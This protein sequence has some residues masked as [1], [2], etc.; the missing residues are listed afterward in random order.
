MTNTDQ[1]VHRYGKV[2]FELNGNSILMVLISRTL[3]SF[4]TREYINYADSE[5][6]VCEPYV[7]FII[8]GIDR[9]G[10]RTRPLLPEETASIK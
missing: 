6:S 2:S 5:G 1:M 3:F 8:N 10:I 4:V 9:T 7:P